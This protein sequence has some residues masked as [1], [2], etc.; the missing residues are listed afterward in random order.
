MSKV[1]DLSDHELAT[2]GLLQ[3]FAGGAMMTVTKMVNNPETF[4]R[5]TDPRDLRRMMYLLAKTALEMAANNNGGDT[6][7]VHD[8]EIIQALIEA[9]QK[10][11]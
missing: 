9:L 8:I 2:A 1:T 3:S 11:T 10:E 7:I 4:Y 5:D 6:N